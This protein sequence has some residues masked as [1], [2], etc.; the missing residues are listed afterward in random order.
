MRR[1]RCAALQSVPVSHC[2]AVVCCARVCGLLREA[3]IRPDGHLS[4][5]SV[6]TLLWIVCVSVVRWAPLSKVASAGSMARSAR[7]FDLALATTKA[8]ARKSAA[9]IFTGVCVGR[10]G[11]STGRHLRRR[12]GLGV[13]AAPAW[14][15][16]QVRGSV[17]GLALLSVAVTF[18]HTTHTHTHTPTRR[19]TSHVK[20]CRYVTG[21]VGLVGACWY[22]E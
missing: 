20:L 21:V 15:W 7:H 9:R 17:C 12:C 14:G 4:C 11:V 5:Q 1:I 16:V 2:R 6:R 3:A 13:R 22:S 10:G 8:V 19:L 18:P